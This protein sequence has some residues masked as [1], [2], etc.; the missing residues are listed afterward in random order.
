MEVATA[1]DLW[2]M[3]C[4]PANAEFSA[5]EIAIPEKHWRWDDYPWCHVSSQ[6]TYRHMEIS[7]PGLVISL[8][9]TVWW[10]RMASVMISIQ[11]LIIGCFYA[12]N[13][14]MKN[15]FEKAW[16]AQN[17][18]SQLASEALL[19]HRTITAFSLQERMLSLFAVTMEGPRK[20][21]ITQSWFSGVGL[22]S[23]QFFSTASTALSFWY[24]GR[25]LNQGLVSSKQLFQAFFILMSTGKTIAD[26]GS[27][28]SDLVKG[29]RAVISVFAILD[30]KSEIAPDDQEGIRVDTDIEGNI[31]A[32][33]GN[34]GSGKSTIIGL[35]ERFYDPLKGSILI[36]GVDIKAYNLRSLRSRIPLVS[37]EPTLFAGTIRQNI[38]YGK[39]DATE[40]E[41]REAANLA[42]AHEFIRFGHAM[43][44]KKKPTI[45]ME[46]EGGMFSYADNIDKLLMLFGTLGSIGDGMIIPGVMFL[47]S[48]LIDTYGNLEPRSSDISS[49]N[50]TVDKYGLKLMYLATGVGISAFVAIDISLNVALVLPFVDKNGLQDSS[51]TTFQVISGV[52]SDVQS[53]QDVIAEK[54]LHFMAGFSTLIGCL[55]VSSLLSWRL[56]LAA[57]PLTLL[58]IAPG[59][60]LR[61]LMMKLGMKMKDS[62]G[63]AGEIAEQAIS[64]IRMVYSSVGERQTQNRFSKA[65]QKYT[66]LGLQEDCMQYNSQFTYF[67]DTWVR[68]HNDGFWIF[69]HLMSALPNISFFAEAKAAATRI[70]ELIDQVPRIDTEDQKG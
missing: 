60:G 4:S 53:I 47:L 14:A 66:E 3:A 11:P 67:T 39:E 68:A 46:G 62:Y 63:V 26:A 20:E 64:S 7:N 69:R 34:S 18:G 30:R 49:A 44:A 8:R 36:D 9:P 29:S 42:N 27:M 15:M 28:T 16:E 6:W 22:F 21:I 61:K 33:I 12:K 5:M 55:I 40:S 57:V 2:T 25:F 58:F 48:G 31:V 70:S 43:S 37:Q 56:F 1:A 51:S 59:L 35:I 38:A 32:L 50:C 54:I 45:N 10:I 23:S 19:S 52:S 17:K 13:T 24:G 65:L 41:L